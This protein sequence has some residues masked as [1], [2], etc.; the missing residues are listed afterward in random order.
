L[1]ELADARHPYTAA[2]PSFLPFVS[3]DGGQPTAIDGASGVVNFN[4]ATMFRL[5][6][7]FAPPRAKYG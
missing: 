2:L 3:S 6:F 4:G 1:A 7:R 5:A